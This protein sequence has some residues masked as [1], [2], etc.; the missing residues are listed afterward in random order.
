MR[1]LDYSVSGDVKNPQVLCIAKYDIYVSVTDY[2][3]KRILREIIVAPG[4]HIWQ[5]ISLKEDKPIDI[6]DRENSYTK[7][8]DAINRMVRDN[9]STVYA[10]DN[11]KEMVNH[12]NEIT[13]KDKI[14][15]IYRGD[16]S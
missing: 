8:D 9:Y 15:T 7:F 5:W 3:E 12:W 11:F 14:V 4:N 6:G 13:Y 16:N 1:I 10:F 2:G